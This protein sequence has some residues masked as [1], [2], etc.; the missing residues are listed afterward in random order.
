[1]FEDDFDYYGEQRKRR[2]KENSEEIEKTFDFSILLL[3]ECRE[4]LKED[5]RINRAKI[6]RTRLTVSDLLK[7]LES[8]NAW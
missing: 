2:E 3:E 1:M 8:R 5:Y 7:K 6:Q 4:S